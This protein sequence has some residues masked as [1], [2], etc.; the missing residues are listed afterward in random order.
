MRK[1]FYILF[2]ARGEDGQLRK[3]PVPMHYM[4]VLIAGAAIVML[5]LTGIA[6]SYARML[7]KVSR[8]DELRTQK[9]ELKNR[10]TRLEEVAKERDIQVASLGSLA[11]EVSSLYGLKPDPVL[12]SAASSDSVQD[13]Q[14]SSSLDRLYTLKTTAMSGATKIG[15]A[16]V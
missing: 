16:H 10:Y 2:V 3:I 1:R 11:S 4:Y 14:L 9:D 15:R 12:V 6:S 7:L 13:V 5:G 8:Y